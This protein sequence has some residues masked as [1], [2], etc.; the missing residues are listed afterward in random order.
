[1]KKLFIVT[2]FFFLV[3]CSGVDFVYKDSESPVNPLFQ[4]TD[5]NTSGVSFNFI[6]SYLPMFFGNNNE[7]LFELIIDITERRTKVAVETNQAASNLKYE[8]SFFYT[9]ILKNDNCISYEKEIVSN[10]SIIP[11]S[12]G[13]DYGTDASLEKK[14]E[15]A[16]RESLNQFVSSLSKINIYNCL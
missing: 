15:L 5:V 2:L 12:S 7:D 16:I 3:S 1:M 13:Y 10:F 11:K 14:Y 8:L 4:K 9:L 6:N